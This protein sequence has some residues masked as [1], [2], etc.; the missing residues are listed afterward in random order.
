M[1]TKEAAE[2]VVKLGDVLIENQTSSSEQNCLSIFPSEKI[3]KI[4]VG[5]D[6][7]I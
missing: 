1:I 6:E 2:E 5:N 4:R 7:K 3:K